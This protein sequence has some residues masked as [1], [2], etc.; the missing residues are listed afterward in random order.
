MKLLQIIVITDMFKFPFL[1][2]CNF[3]H[4]M[5]KIIQCRRLIWNH[6]GLKTSS[7]SLVKWYLVQGNIFWLRVSFTG[8]QFRLRPAERDP[9]RL[10]QRHWLSH[11][12][13]YWWWCQP[14]LLRSSW[15]QGWDRWCPSGCPPPQSRGTLH[16]A[17]QL[18]AAIYGYVLRRQLNTMDL[19]LK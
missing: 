7:N 10:S 2:R 14:G 11:L 16:K 9:S 13:R 15:R 5:T 8:W 4:Q 12:W 6:Q 3:F 19:T 1:F 17:K 18:V